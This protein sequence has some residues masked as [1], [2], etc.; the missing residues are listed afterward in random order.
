MRTRILLAIALCAIGFACTDGQRAIIRGQKS[1]RITTASMEPTL[2]NGEDAFAQPYKGAA[3]PQR[4]DVV[5]F[6]YPIHPNIVFAKRVI[7]V[8]GD[9][10]QIVRKRLYLNGTPLTEGYVIHSDAQVYDTPGLPQPYKSRDTF[11][12]VKVGPGEFFVLGDNRDRSSDSRYWGTVPRGNILGKI[13]SAGE[14]VGELRPI[15]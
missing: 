7:G 2:M 15:Q 4:G 13:V 9:T 6:K 12:P 5:A 1:Y 3:G 8:P 10:I 11:G 14:P